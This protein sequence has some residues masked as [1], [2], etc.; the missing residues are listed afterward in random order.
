MGRLLSAAVVGDRLVLAATDPA[1][2]TEPWSVP[3]AD[4]S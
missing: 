1:H 3:L 4:L 2:G